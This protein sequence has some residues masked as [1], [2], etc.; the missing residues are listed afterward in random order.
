MR[1]L[2][3]KVLEKYGQEVALVREDGRRAVRALF[4]PVEEKREGELPSPLGRAP[5]GR[6]LYLGPP[7]GGQVGRGA[8]GGG[9]GAEGKLTVGA[10]WVEGRGFRI[11]RYREYWVG[12]EKIYWWAVAE[13]REAER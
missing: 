3:E 7:G 1:E 2:W 4:Q 12:G 6:Y 9:G 10:V 8:W 11:L 5:V 13:E